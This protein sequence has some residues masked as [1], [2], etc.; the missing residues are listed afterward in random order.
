MYRLKATI[1]NT[2]SYLHTERTKGRYTYS[3]LLKLVAKPTPGRA[4]KFITKGDAMAFTEEIN[5]ATRYIARMKY[6]RDAAGDQYEPSYEFRWGSRNQEH[7]VT[8]DIASVNWEIEALHDET[9]LSHDE[10][11]KAACAFLREK[12]CSIVVN[13][14]AALCNDESPDA[15]GFHGYN[16]SHLV[17]A[18]T[19]KADFFADK[20]KL[21]RINPERGVGT[22]RWFICE[23]YLIG[24]AEVPSNWG[25]IYATKGQR[26]VV[27]DP[28][29]QERNIAA[30]MYLLYQ[31]ARRGLGGRDKE[32]L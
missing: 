12:N 7:V 31:T 29:W 3:I 27:K 18:K 21:F 5:N 25:L 4:K 17:E 6:V 13:Q 10:L 16:E 2:V 19:S 15:I 23:P 32:Q 22:Y 24:V 20:Y 11:C 8:E 14:P 30:E 28:E 26:K 9:R 1:N